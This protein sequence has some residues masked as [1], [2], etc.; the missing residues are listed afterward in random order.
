MYG[1]VVV[2][3]PELKFREFDQYRSYY[4]GLCDVLKDRYGRNGQLCISYD[5]T[6]LILLLT[7]LYEPETTY[8]EEKCIAHPIVKHQVRRN[9][10]TEYVADLNVL[11]TYYKCL[12]D[13]K[14]EKKITRKAMASG[15]KK[16]AQRVM[17]KYPNKAEVIRES[18]ES[19][20]HAEEANETNIDQVA[21]Y[22][23]RIMSEMA[24]I[25]QDE[26][27]DTL[28]KL[29]FQLG[30][31]IYL[32]DAYDDLESDVKAGRYNV[33]SSYKDQPDF[34]SYCEIILNAVMSE[35]AKQFE[36]LPILQDAEILRNII[37]SGVWT[38]YEIAHNRKA[39][40]QEKN[41]DRSI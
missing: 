34:D 16:K 12:D 23:G 5:C 32:L 20:S 9:Q 27:E 38:R 18:L 7:G 11:M 22:F 28:R 3:K 37:Y 41:I 10:I 36:I 14:D 33:L 19:L 24:A 8:S 25:Y 17:E 29:G 26:W 4:C 21:G 31:F 40:R 35:C 2:N 30:K 1:Y 15:L 6:F 13:W 39:N